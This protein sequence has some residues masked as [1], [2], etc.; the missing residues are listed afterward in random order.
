MI[1]LILAR[2]AGPVVGPAATIVAVIALGLAVSQCSG[3]VKAERLANKAEAARVAAVADLRTCQ[4]NR[5]ALTTAIDRQNAA[6]DALKREGEAK[7]AESRKAVS[8]AR[9]VAESHR[10]E[11]A[12]IL[13]AK[14]KGD[15][16]SAA[17]A[18]VLEV[19]R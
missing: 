11:A 5:A 3:R 6:V 2:L 13:A 7:V 17:D 10:R 8:A 12:R 18:L 1:G 4:A 9:S 15:A 14:P 19:V 16:C